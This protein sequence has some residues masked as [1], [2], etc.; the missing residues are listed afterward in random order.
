MA[1]G[2][3]FCAGCG[4]AAVDP[5]ATRLARTNS[6]HP[7]TTG[8]GDVERIIFNARPTLLYVKIG[9]ILAALGAIGMVIL[10]AMANV[11]AVISVPLGL[12][13]LLIPAYK[14]LKRNMIRYTLTDSKVE[15]D[16]GL[17]ARTTRRNSFGQHHAANTWLRKR[18][19]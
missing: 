17:I 16:C 3:K 11:P 14:H 5:E 19:H 7:A 9:Y 15:I 13:L 4:A 18:H 6:A 12:S 2:T 10:L 1:P 8:D